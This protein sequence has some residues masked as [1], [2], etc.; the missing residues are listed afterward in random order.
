MPDVVEPEIE[1]DTEWRL[2]FFFPFALVEKYAG[3]L[4]DPAGTKW[5][6]NFYK[7]GDKTSHPHWASWNPVKVLNF[8][9]P[10]CF[11]DIIFES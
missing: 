8:H 9:L 1:E 2:G 7:C 3:K 5:T 10:E 6:A 4:G 11:G